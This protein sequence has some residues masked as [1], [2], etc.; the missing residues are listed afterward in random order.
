MK[1]LT[2][3]TIALFFT[4]GMAFAQSNDATVDQVGSDNDASISQVGS[5]NDADVTQ[6]GTHEASVTQIGV[7]NS[8]TVLQQGPDT[9][10]SVTQ[11]QIGNE[12]SATALYLGRS[13]DWAGRDGVISQIQTGDNNTAYAVGREGANLSQEQIGND[14]HAQIG[15]PTGESGN[16]NGIRRVMTVDQYQEGDHNTAY[17]EPGFRFIRDGNISQSQI[18]DGNLAEAL[19]LTNAARINQSQLGDD[20]ISIVTEGNSNFHANTTQEGDFNEAYIT[21][22]GHSENTISQFGNS[23]FGSIETSSHSSGVIL[24]DGDSNSAVISQSN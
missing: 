9:E 23:N 24:Q 3:L 10:S 2:T 15:D 6:S 11:T 18:G 17:V 1:K 8:A 19:G 16:P 5:D 14:N 21:T 13:N 4:A 22:G 20:N 7:D 12:N